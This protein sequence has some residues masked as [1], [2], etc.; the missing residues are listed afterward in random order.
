MAEAAE[1]LAAGDPQA[2]ESLDCGDLPALRLRDVGGAH[3]L[4]GTR[5]K[6]PL[7][8][9][10]LRFRLLHRFLC[11]EIV[12]LRILPR[13]AVLRQIG[14]R[15]D[16]QRCRDCDNAGL[17]FHR[18]E[19]LVEAEAD[20]RALLLVALFGERFVAGGDRFVLREDRAVSRRVDRKRRVE[21]GVTAALG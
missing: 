7:R 5:R 12:V 6:R 1:K 13:L 9:G 15:I 3:T 11:D 20:A 8:G 18:S 21:R 14:I 4:G 16:L 2:R 17:S 10:E 19:G